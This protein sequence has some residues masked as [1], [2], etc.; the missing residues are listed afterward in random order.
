MSANGNI[1]RL[2]KRWIIATAIL[3]VIVISSAVAVGSFH[4]DHTTRPNCRSALA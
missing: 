1:R 4:T 2:T 3:A